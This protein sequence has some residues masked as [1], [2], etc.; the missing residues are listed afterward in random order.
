MA[1]DKPNPVSSDPNAVEKPSSK[2]R[3]RKEKHT[4]AE[5]DDAHELPT[6]EARS[7]KDGLKKKKKKRKLANEETLAEAEPAL[8]TTVEEQEQPFEGTSSD[9]KSKKKRKE[10]HKHRTADAGAADQSNNESTTSSNAFLSAVMTAA[11]A[12][13]NLQAQSQVGYVFPPME[14][15][16]NQLGTVGL[17]GLNAS[18]SSEDLARTLNSMDVAK[19]ADAL[20]ALGDAG[21]S[22][23]TLPGQPAPP[24]AMMQMGN[25]AASGS[26]QRSRSQAPRKASAAPAFSAT[27]NLQPQQ[28]ETH[29]DILSRKWLNTTKLN[30]LSKEI[31][32]G[33]RVIY[34]VFVLTNCRLGLVYKK[35]KFSASEIVALKQAIENYRIVSLFS[36]V[37]CMFLRA[38]QRNS[39]TPE[40]MN[41]VIFPKGTRNKDN[42]FWFDISKPTYSPGLTAP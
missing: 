31:G 38:F 28:N 24:H 32:E 17:D 4:E 2:K 10:K 21:S 7:A 36:F 13:Q 6:E 16:H 37:F 18:L 23:F 20:R 3:K 11:A 34:S 35:G 19:I 26:N 14:L 41:E 27:P 40:Q 29:A 22:S 12:G 1:R 8:A 15:S 30:E 42:A 25:H 5:E 33:V 39:L 9:K